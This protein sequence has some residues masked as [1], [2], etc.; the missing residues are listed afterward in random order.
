MLTDIFW[1]LKSYCVISEWHDT[2]SVYKAACQS[3]I[4]TIFFSFDMAMSTLGIWELLN[5]PF[6]LH[7]N[8]N[9]AWESRRLDIWGNKTFHLSHIFFCHEVW[10]NIFNSLIDSIISY[11]D[12]IVP[13]TWTLPKSCENS[14]I[15]SLEINL[16]WVGRVLST[17]LGFQRSIIRRLR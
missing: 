17:A 14:I 16:H 5:L 8:R 13:I 3:K 10:I 1:R 2:D 11:T 15:V 12:S 9:K 6:S 7:K 4:A